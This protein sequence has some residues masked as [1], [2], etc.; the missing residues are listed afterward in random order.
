MPL[1]TEVEAW[2]AER[3]K[4]LGPNTVVGFSFGFLM[5]LLPAL[6]QLAEAHR[7]GRSIGSINRKVMELANENDTPRPNAVSAGWRARVM[8]AAPAWVS[9]RGALRWRQS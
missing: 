5:S 3:N 4:K 1:S 6:L 7:Q 2:I 8:L 9:S